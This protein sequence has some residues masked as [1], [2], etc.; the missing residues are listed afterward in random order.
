MVSC[1]EDPAYVC[2][3]ACMY[4][5]MYVHGGLA[6]G[7]MHRRSY[8]CMHKYMCM[9][10]YHISYISNFL[11][12]CTCVYTHIHTH[13]YFISTDIFQSIYSGYIQLYAQACM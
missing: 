2:M 11:D 4:Q 8:A 5:C 13:A 10:M 1:T 7:E 6:S 9:C 12:I 3:C